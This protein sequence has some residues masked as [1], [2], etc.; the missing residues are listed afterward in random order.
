MMQLKKPLILLTVAFLSFFLILSSTTLAIQKKSRAV[1][2]IKSSEPSGVFGWVAI[3]DSSTG[4]HWVPDNP[5]TQHTSKV[6]YP[7]KL[8][9]YF[10]E[11]T[12]GAAAAV[13]THRVDMHAGGP[14]D[15]N[16]PRLHNA[17]YYSV[18][19]EH[20]TNMTGNPREAGTHKVQYNPNKWRFQKVE[21]ATY[22]NQWPDGR[23]DWT[24]SFNR[25][26]SPFPDLPD[27][28]Y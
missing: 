9:I 5:K 12:S 21:V 16:G 26:A 17:W 13:R 1:K 19:F 24:V 8:T 18:T 27:S 28:L 7:G 23:V 10:I 3:T 11:N 15:M 20:L 25:R 14:F 2:S 6:G 22:M 4:R